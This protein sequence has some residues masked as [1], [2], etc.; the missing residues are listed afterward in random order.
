MDDANAAD[1]SSLL[2]EWKTAFFAIHKRNPR[3]ADW[4][5]KAP[6]A[7]R[8]AYMTMHGI[9]PAELIVSSSIPK[10]ANSTNCIR[11]KRPAADELVSD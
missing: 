6:S 2:E 11:L 10:K 5:K 7:V 8:Q 1:S 3:K 9:E 4:L